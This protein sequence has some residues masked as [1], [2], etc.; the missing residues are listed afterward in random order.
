MVYGQRPPS[1]LKASV[2]SLSTT[3]VFLLELSG[4]EFRETFPSSIKRLKRAYGLAD[5]T[6]ERE[7]T[8]DKTL[9]DTLR[10]ECT[11]IHKKIHIPIHIEDIYKGKKLKQAK[12]Q[13]LA[14]VL[15]LQ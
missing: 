13:T 12:L 1:K 2:P 8:T 9:E 15:K 4:W 11:S 5:S 7:R 10:A 6:Q 14:W 3:R